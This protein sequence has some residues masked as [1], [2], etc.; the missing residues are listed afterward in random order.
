MVR[1]FQIGAILGWEGLKAGCVNA[2]AHC[3][4]KRKWSIQYVADDWVKRITPRLATVNMLFVKLFQSIACNR[5]WISE[6]CNQWLAQYTDHV[7]WMESDIDRALISHISTRFQ[8]IIDPIP[9]NAGMIS[10]VFKAHDSTGKE[11]AVKIKR[12]NIYETLTQSI[13][14]IVDIMSWFSYCS[15]P[16]FDIALITNNMYQLQTQTDF[17]KEAECLHMFGLMCATISYVRIPEVKL[18]ITRE[19]PNVIVMEWLHGKTIYQ[20]QHTPL[21]REYA[22][23]VIRFGFMCSLVHGV[24]H[25]DLHAGNILFMEHNETK[26]PQIGILDFG[27]MYTF[28]EEMRGLLL[29]VFMKLATNTPREFASH[30]LNSNLVQIDGQMNE[31]MN[32]QIDGQMNEKQGLLEQLTQEQQEFAIHQVS[33]L[34]SDLLVA[35]KHGGKIHIYVFFEQFKECV[36][37]ISAFTK[38]KLTSS[39]LLVKC[40]LMLLMSHGVT[41]ALCGDDFIT[42]AEDTIHSMF[43]LPL[44]LGLEE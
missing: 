44:L 34:I 20:I 42:L 38:I 9:V 33:L 26:Q 41:I 36:K 18:D 6:P 43:H 32:K 13:G 16:L 29:S 35:Y 28:P 14:D 30:L 23:H 21:A 31:Q 4:K 8:M 1:L 40:Q 25:G 17:L 10:L 27:M 5:K 24:A 37:K 19:C 11:F 7:P 39:D 15:I 3:F 12:V 22:Q 2:I